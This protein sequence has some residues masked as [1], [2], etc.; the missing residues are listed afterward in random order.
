M[1]NILHYILIP[2]KIIFFVILLIIGIFLLK[3]TN[4]DGNVTTLIIV[5]FKFVVHYLMSFN[6][7]IS[8]KDYNKYMKY[9]YSDEKFICVFNHITT[10]DGFILLSTFP[11]MGIVLN[12]QKV[13][14]YIGYDDG[15][16]SKSGSI[17]VNED[18][19]SNVT[20]KIKE[21]IYN[22]KKG[23]SALFISP[24]Y[25]LPDEEN[26]IS[27]F[28]KK[29]AFV[30]KS[31][32]LPIIIKYE[33]YSIIYNYEHE[34][35]LASIFKLFLFEN[36]KIKIKIG[37]MIDP[38]ENESIEEYKERVYHIMNEQYKDI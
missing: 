22:R 18:K 35:V 5:F 17:F 27:K 31:K 16:N 6:I 36:Y 38:S 30:S 29:G 10:L 34:N 21:T 14:D 28:I 8:D 1:V 7:E 11:K 12:K 9:V 25:T 37:D 24:T 20:T 23:Q 2:F 19:K 3:N 32:I 13:F 15:S 26:N 4:G 33:D